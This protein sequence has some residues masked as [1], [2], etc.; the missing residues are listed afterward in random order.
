MRQWIGL[1]VLLLPLGAAAIALAQEQSPQQPAKEVQLP[2]D[3]EPMPSEVKAGFRKLHLKCGSCHEVARAEN[4]KLELN[5]WPA[6]LKKMRE[7][8]PDKIRKSDLDDIFTYIV[9]RNATREAAPIANGWQ[10]FAV[11]C[12]QCH[13]VSLSLRSQYTV[14]QWCRVVAQMAAKGNA[15]HPISAADQAEMNT[16]LAHYV[17]AMGGVSAVQ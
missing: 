11:K 1:A 17:K 14:E 6:T 4:A 5:R 7:K 8:A 9:H 10:T 13:S 3:V 12:E 16:F 2:K 15:K